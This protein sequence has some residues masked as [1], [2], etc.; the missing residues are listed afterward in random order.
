VSTLRHGQRLVAQDFAHR[1]RKEGQRGALLRAAATNDRG[2]AFS[3][4]AGVGGAVQIKALVSRQGRI[5]VFTNVVINPSSPN[6]AGG[7]IQYYGQTQANAGCAFKPPVTLGGL[8]CSRLDAGMDGSGRFQIVS[9]SRFGGESRVQ[10]IAQQQD[11]RRS[12]P[13]KT[14]A[15]ATSISGE[16]HVRITR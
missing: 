14:S 16:A 15:A 10:M 9:Q 2:T 8:A 4:A 1:A 13:R 5:G 3:Y 11:E 6:P 7:E 12:G